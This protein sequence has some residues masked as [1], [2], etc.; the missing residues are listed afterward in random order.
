YDLTSQA[1][2]LDK[3][4]LLTRTDN[5]RKWEAEGKLSFEDVLDLLVTIPQSK[6][7]RMKRSYAER[8]GIQQQTQ[9]QLEQM[10]QQLS[11]MQ[12]Q[13]TLVFNTLDLVEGGAQVKKQIE[14]QMLIANQIAPA[15]QQEQPQ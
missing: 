3:V 11:A 4:D 8:Q 15:M 12:A 2:Q 5:L 10:S 14:N 7:D 13:V 1:E 6:R 9:Q